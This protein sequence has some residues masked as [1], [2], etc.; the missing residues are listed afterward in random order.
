MPGRRIAPLLLIAL[1]PLAACTTDMR[2]ILSDDAARNR[3]IETL[4]GDQASRGEVVGRLLS[5]PADRKDLFQAVLAD[6]EVA[7]AWTRQLMQNDRGMALLAGQ[8]AAD[9]EGTRTFM[10]MLMSTGAL[11]EVLTQEQAE[12]LG[13]GDA[14]AYGNLR[15]TMVDLKRLGQRVEDSVRQS[16]GTYPVCVRYDDVADCLASHLPAD[17]LGNLRLTD[18]WGR[19]FRY[20]S[21]DQGKS[22]TLVS[23][24]TDGVYDQMGRAGPTSSYDAD[25]VYSDGDFVQWLGR[26]RKDAI[27]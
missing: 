18:A 11:G 4:V 7:S 16:D 17:A 3:A 10:T 13:L 27:K 26:I 1:A 5:N 25:I 8:I 23:Y 12:V 21:D 24:A 2:E 14:F 15:R 6:D 9:R 22:Y 19:P 20:H